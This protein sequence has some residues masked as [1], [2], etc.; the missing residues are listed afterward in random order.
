M[1]QVFVANVSSGL[2]TAVR[3]VEPLILESKAAMGKPKIL[4][5]YLTYHATGFMAEH[6]AEITGAEV[7]VADIELPIKSEEEAVNRCKEEYH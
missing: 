1:L 3:A 7:V 5:N 2:N 4:T 6:L